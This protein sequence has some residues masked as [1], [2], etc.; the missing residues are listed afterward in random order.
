MAVSPPITPSREVIRENDT[1]YRRSLSEA[2]LTKFGAVINFINNRIVDRYVFNFGGYYKVTSLAQ[3]TFE[4]IYIKELT[5]ISY[6]TMKIDLTASSGDNEI[7][8]KVINE[9]GVELGD[10][11]SVAP[12]I[13][14]SSTANAMVGRDIKNNTTILKV[15]TDALNYDFGALN[16]SYLQLPQGYELKPYLV[17]GSTN[18]LNLT[19]NLGLEA[20]S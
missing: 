6:Y 3:Y 1:K 18:A 11:F 20:Q 13:N 2:I 7:N 17:S 12:R 5:N 8:F 9:L 4:S 15:L 16:P 10:L 19:I 14:Q